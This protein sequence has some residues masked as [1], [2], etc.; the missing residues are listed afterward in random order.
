VQDALD[1]VPA[2]VPTGNLTTR[3]A[4]DRTASLVSPASRPA[5]PFFRSDAS[6]APATSLPLREWT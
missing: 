6:P 4:G 3:A 1:D 2:L 5:M